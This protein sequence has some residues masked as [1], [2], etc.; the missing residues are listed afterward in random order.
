MY[1]TAQTVNNNNNNNNNNNSYYYYYYYYYYIN[2][3]VTKIF[4]TLKGLSAERNVYCV[5]F[6]MCQLRLNGTHS[7]KEKDKQL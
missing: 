7:H 6:Q 3:L 5:P 2:D 1:A 4:T